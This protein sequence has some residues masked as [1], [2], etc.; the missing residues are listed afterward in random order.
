MAIVAIASI[1]FA[2]AQTPIDENSTPADNS[3]VTYQT[4]QGS[5]DTKNWQ[6][7]FGT[8][9][10]VWQ[11]SYR[12]F[13]LMSTQRG[14]NGRIAYR[15]Y[16]GSTS[17]WIG[18]REL[19]NRDEQGRIKIPVNGAYSTASGNING[20][21]LIEGN[22]TEGN[23][24][25]GAALSFSRL[26]GGHNKRASIVAKQ[27]SGDNDNVGLAFMTHSNTSANPTVERMLIT[28]DGNIGIGTSAPD[29]KVHIRHRQS[30]LSVNTRGSLNIQVESGGYS[31]GARSRFITSANRGFIDYR[32]ETSGHGSW[33]F[34]S[35]F[36]SIRD[37]LTVNGRTSRVGVGTVE[38]AAKFHVNNTATLGGK[39]ATANAGLLI[40]GNGHSLMMDE[41]E[42]YSTTNLAIGAAYDKPII[43]RSVNTSGNTERMRIAPN[44]N[45]GI[46]VDNPTAP[47]SVDGNIMSKEVTVDPDFQD[48]PDYVFAEDYELQPLAEVKAYVKA[49]KHLP[50]VPSAAEM[51]ENGLKLKDM[52]LLLLKK[53]E[54][55]TLHQIELMEEVERLKN[56]VKDL[57]GK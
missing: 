30:D 52:S 55:M 48:I 29:S 37:I 18:W 9:L 14:Y 13:E 35:Q 21:I 1:Q 27:T 50:E 47:L 46:G 12:N 36:N 17:S 42:V 25:Y 49:N 2:A 44:G 11:T 7:K 3:G 33:I 24:L 4:G 22:G 31:G 40:T 51:S 19:L 15:T 5:N 53:I 23:N 32:T 41:N 34:G 16:D 26:A 6:Y 8:K 39:T 57:E 38:P 54:E 56:K 45:V 43:F 28:G 20:E 10:S